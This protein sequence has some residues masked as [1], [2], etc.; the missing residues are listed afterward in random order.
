MTEHD[1]FSPVSRSCLTGIVLTALVALAPATASAEYRLFPGDSLEI[2]ALGMPELKYRAQINVDGNISFPVLGQIKVGGLPISEVRAKVQ[3]LLPK[4]EL[5]RRTEDGREFPIILAPDDIDVTV[6]EYRPVYLNGDVSKPGEQ[7]FRPGMTARQA[8]ALAGGYDIMRFR[9]NNPFLEQADLQSE[10]R[11]LWNELAKEQARVARLRAELK[12][13]GQLD[14]SA[15]QKTTNPSPIAAEIQNVERDR[16]KLRATDFS[17]ERDYLHR[18]GSQEDGR[19]ATLSE[20]QQKEQEGAKIDAEDLKRLQE[21]YQRGNTP[22][23]RVQEARRSILLSATRELQTIT[24]LAQVE[25]ERLDIDRKLER[26]D[27]QRRLDILQEL[28]EANVK[29]AGVR[30]RIEA[31]SEKLVYTGMVRSQLVRGKENKPNLLVVRKTEKGTER[32]TVDED[33]ELLPGDVVEVALKADL[34]PSD[35]KD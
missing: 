24:Q 7:P 26:L 12:G 1:G 2:T 13:D 11:S 19:I 8:V 21:L 5:R 16:M 20:R 35:L 10:Y 18:A 33:T 14:Q 4:K 9:M 34:T 22:I 23:T 28:Q 29:A 15:L 25:R 6:I 17:K 31:V 32:L 3:A 30:S 27:D